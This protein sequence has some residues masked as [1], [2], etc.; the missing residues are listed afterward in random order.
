[1]S[2][3]ARMIEW[4]DEVNN[5]SEGGGGAYAELVVPN[6]YE[7][8]L[9]AVADYDKRDIGKSWGWLFTYEVIT[10]SGRP[11][12]FNE[13][14]SFGTNARWKLQE[15]LEAHGH[16]L[17][18][19]TEMIDPNLLVGEVIVGHIDFDRDAAGEPKSP[20]RQIQRHYSLAT[21]PTTSTED[22]EVL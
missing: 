8:E 4:G 7:M 15:V 2:A 10:P 18:P 21:P 12:Q 3:T 1:M 22:P 14:L 11:V 16:E 19:G 20:Y 5:P 17:V 9:V 13:Y 6:D